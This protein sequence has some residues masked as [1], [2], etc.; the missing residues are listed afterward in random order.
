MNRCSS[1]NIAM[2]RDK[3][4]FEKRQGSLEALMER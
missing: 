3:A 2:A 4:E 1:I